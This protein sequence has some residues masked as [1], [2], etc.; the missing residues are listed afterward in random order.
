MAE[1]CR[2]DLSGRVYCVTA[3]KKKPTPENPYG[4][5]KTKVDVTDSF[6]Q[7]SR[8]RWNDLYLQARAL[9]AFQIMDL[10]IDDQE[11]P[12][13]YLKENLLHLWMMRQILIEFGVRKDLEV[14]T[15][16]NWAERVA[17]EWA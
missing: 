14:L 7:T 11:D 9:W 10:E 12:E 15:A 17:Q 3:W 8:A 2:S 6:E 5:A 16:E 4:Q 13:T 1:L